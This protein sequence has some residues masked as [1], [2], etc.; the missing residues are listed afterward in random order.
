MQLFIL[1]NYKS[2]D[3]QNTLSDLDWPFEYLKKKGSK[4][5]YY[6]DFITFSTSE[7][8]PYMCIKGR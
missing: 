4:Y 8:K 1:D 7:A 3:T 2:F 5:C 6:S